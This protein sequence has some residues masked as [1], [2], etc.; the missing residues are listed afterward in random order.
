MLGITMLLDI[1]ASLTPQVTTIVC[2]HIKKN[3]IKKRKK[4]KK[5]Q[6]YGKLDQNPY[7]NKNDT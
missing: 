6:K 5:I 7:V 3:I 4:R 1:S 2:H